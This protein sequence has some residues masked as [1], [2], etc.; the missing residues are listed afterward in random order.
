MLRSILF[1]LAFAF[2]ATLSSQTK[3]VK[4]STNLGDMSF[5]LYDDTPKHRDA[6]LKLTREGYYNETLFYRV[7][8]D[9]LIQGGSKSSVNAPQ[10]KGV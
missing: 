3:K 1:I 7:M 4:I 5:I 9:F 2:S 8:K 10:V 6:F